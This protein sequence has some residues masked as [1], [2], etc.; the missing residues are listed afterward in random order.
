MERLV[1]LHPQ[2]LAGTVLPLTAGRQLIGRGARADLRLDDRYLSAA[3]AAIDLTA[4]RATVEDLGSAN[5]TRVDG[6]LIAGLRP[7]RDGD[8][9]T[10]GNVD[11]RFE[12]G[13]PTV[14]MP[15]SAV[16]RPPPDPVTFTVERQTGHQINNVGRDQINSY[17][18]QR[19]SFLRAVAASRTKARWVFWIGLFMLVGGGIGYAYFLID[20]ISELNDTFGDASAGPPDGMLF[21]G[22]DTSLGMPAGL[23]CFAVAFVGQFLLIIGLIMWIVAAARVRKVDRD[24]RHAWNSPFVR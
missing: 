3:H 1:I 20:G 16:R 9:L 7:L 10:F 12:Q 22:P 2:E 21:F 11:A 24:P 6:E 15:S 19:E 14:T 18:E 23:I 4:G 5:G 13:P 8:I 17:I